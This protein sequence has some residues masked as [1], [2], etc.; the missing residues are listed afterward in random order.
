MIK[1]GKHHVKQAAA[2]IVAGLTLMKLAASAQG[3]RDDLEE[4]DAIPL[5]RLRLLRLSVGIEAV[6]DL[7]N[8][9]ARA[10]HN[11]SAGS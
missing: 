2:L 5:G 8:D 7:W 3:V 9:L 6:E 10:L 11:A 1:S 4:S